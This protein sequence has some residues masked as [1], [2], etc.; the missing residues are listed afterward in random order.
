MSTQEK[1]RSDAIIV[2]K[3]RGARLC[4]CVCVGGAGYKCL[5]HKLNDRYFDR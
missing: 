4:V 1:A 3:A 2:G 5:K